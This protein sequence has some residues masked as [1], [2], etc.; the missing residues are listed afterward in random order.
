MVS[1]HAPA[2]FPKG[3]VF[4]D[5]SMVIRGAPRPVIGTSRWVIS[6]SR[7]VIGGPRHVTG[8]PRWCQ[9]RPK[10]TVALREVTKH[11][12]ITLMLHL[13]QSAKI[14]DTTK[15]SPNVLLGT[16][17]LLTSMHLSNTP[18]HLRQVRRLLVTKI[19]FENVLSL[20]YAALCINSRIW[21]GEIERDDLTW[22]S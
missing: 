16:D 21:H 20:V 3:M 19:H 7:P 15:A 14:P 17:S 10:F 2:A 12:T 4:L 6:A 18:N 8:T 13:Y 22:S 1:R 9:A 5:Y 11:I